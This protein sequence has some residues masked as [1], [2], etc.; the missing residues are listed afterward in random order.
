MH[1]EIHSPSQPNKVNS[2]TKT[3]CALAVLP[4]QNQGKSHNDISK[5]IT[6]AFSIKHNHY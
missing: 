6:D 3:E 4:G 5:Q 1:E 2:K